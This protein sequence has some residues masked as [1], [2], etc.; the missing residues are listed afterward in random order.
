MKTSKQTNEEIFSHPVIIFKDNKD[1]KE[2]NHFVK[3]PYNYNKDHLSHLTSLI[4]KDESKAVQSQKEESDINTIVKRF[5]LTGKLPDGIRMPQYGDF[6]NISDYQSALNSVLQAQ[7]SF[8]AM[9]AAIRNRF[10]NDAGEFVEFC[11]NP[12]NREEAEKLG[13]VEKTISAPGNP[14]TPEPVKPAPV[15]GAK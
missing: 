11:G 3:T 1:N 2:T 15:E 12:A 9:P 7:A 8:D 6:T 14:A 10:H 13:L 4:C 5:G